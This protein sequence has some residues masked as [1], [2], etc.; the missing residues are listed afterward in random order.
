MAN[1]IQLRRGGAQ[2]WAN[3]NPTLAQGELGVELDTGRIKIGDG[4]SFYNNLH[5]VH[6][7]TAPTQERLDLIKYDTYYWTAGDRYWKLAEQYYGHRNYW[8]IIAR[9]NNKPTEAHIDIGEEIKEIK[10][11]GYCSILL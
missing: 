7:P 11:K 1:R 4:T 2:E 8:Y 3:S 9:F 6:D 10:L 5:Y